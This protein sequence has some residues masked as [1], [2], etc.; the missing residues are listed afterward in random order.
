MKKNKLLIQNRTRNAP[1]LLNC[2]IYFPKTKLICLYCWGIGSESYAAFLNGVIFLNAAVITTAVMTTH[3]EIALRF[4][5]KLRYLVI[6]AVVTAAVINAALFFVILL[7][8]RT[9]QRTHFQCPDNT[10]KFILF[11]GKYYIYVRSGNVIR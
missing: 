5:L 3:H 4:R 6:C 1:F 10:N 8:L 9:R 11:W 2:I 7:H